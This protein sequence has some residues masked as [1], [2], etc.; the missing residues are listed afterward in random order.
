MTL[1]SKFLATAALAGA[2]ALSGCAHPHGPAGPHHAAP[3]GGEAHRHAAHH[4]PAAAPAVTGPARTVALPTVGEGTEPRE[5]KTVLKEP[6]L[7]V[8]AIVLRKGTVLPEH[9]SMALVTIQALEGRGTV[10]MK[11]GARLPLGPGQ[12]VFV[13]PGAPHAVEPADGGDLVLVV[14]HA[15]SPGE[16][17]P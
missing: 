9:H 12:L 4:G 1:R 17:H 13:P 15:G 14:T 10:V 7:T 16:H 6:G 5:G 11:D 2:L 3:H 8:A